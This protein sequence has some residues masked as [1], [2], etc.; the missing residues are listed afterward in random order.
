MNGVYQ[1]A[2]I[3]R[4]VVVAAI[5]FALLMSQAYVECSVNPLS[6]YVGD[7][8]LPWINWKEGGSRTAQS[9]DVDFKPFLSTVIVGLFFARPM[10]VRS[11][12]GTNC[13]ASPAPIVGLWLK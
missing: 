3:L 10:M 8:S 7:D 12:D 2:N 4:A 9:N 13:A 1:M 6:Y 11:A 5:G